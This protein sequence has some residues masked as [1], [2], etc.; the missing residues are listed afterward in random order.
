MRPRRKDE[1]QFDGPYR[2]AVR[3]L[4][5]IAKSKRPDISNALG[6]VARQAHDPSVQH[7]K[8]IEKIIQYL[9]RTRDLGILCK[10]PPACRLVNV[11]D[12]SFAKNNKGRRSV[13]GGVVLLA[14][15]A[16]SSFSRT[17]RC[18]ALDSAESENFALADVNSEVVFMVE[19]L[20]FFLP[21]RRRRP[22]TVFKDNDEGQ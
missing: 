16:V 6:E 12:S 9:S 5:L 22:V 4:F 15:E 10:T 17:Q 20:E 19:L 3:R 2:E 14:S 13:S 1:E 7:C 11:A 18:A 21:H 8:A